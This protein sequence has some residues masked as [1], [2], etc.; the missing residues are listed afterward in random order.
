MSVVLAY[1]NNKTAIIAGD[2]RVYD[3]K[4]KIIL[5]EDYKKTMK[6]NK[7]VIIGFTGN[8]D[9][10]TK[11]KKMI[12]SNDRINGTS[13]VDDVITF[14]ER[15]MSEMPKEAFVGIAICGI[16]KEGKM[17]LVAIST[18]QGTTI[19]YP[20]NGKS[21]F[22][23]LPPKGAP[24]DNDIFK[25]KLSELCLIEAIKATIEYY[26]ENFPSVNNKITFECIEVN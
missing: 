15:F 2:S 16:N 1:A 24:D 23:V 3:P 10:C 18:S 14:V 13:F 4:N 6:I 22:F 17:C 26:S 21:H 5:Q 11:L 9:Q 8:C 12:S 19:K 25:E 20:L 7:Q